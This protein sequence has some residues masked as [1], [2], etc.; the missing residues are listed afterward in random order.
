M[1]AGI[2]VVLV[3]FVALLFGTIFFAAW[4]RTQYDL[5]LAP[6]RAPVVPEP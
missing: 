3:I 2:L 6:L 4:A 1:A 5:Y